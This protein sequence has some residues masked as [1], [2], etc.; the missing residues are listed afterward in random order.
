MGLWKLW[1][2]SVEVKKSE[3]DSDEM[4]VAGYLVL[5]DG[6]EASVNMLK[7]TSAVFTLLRNVV[8]LDT[9]V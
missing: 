8:G 3:F 2:H 9:L 5:L 4:D 6:N 7:Q 1:D